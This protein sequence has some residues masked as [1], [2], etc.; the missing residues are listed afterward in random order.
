MKKYL[1]L[2]FSLA[3]FVGC[4]DKDADKKDRLYLKEIPVKG[5]TIEWF[6]YSLIGNT[7]ADFVL[8]YDPVNDK[9]DT[10]IKSTNL[11]DV[12]LSG[13]NIILLFY[14]KPEKYSEPITVKSNIA[15]FNIKVDTTAVFTGYKRRESYLKK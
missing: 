11:K 3:L 10:I 6:Y 15:G 9:N 4:K 12:N 5:K 1:I 13:N 8:L 2:F 14:G 7:T